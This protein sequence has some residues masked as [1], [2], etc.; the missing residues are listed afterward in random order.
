MANAAEGYSKTAGGP[1]SLR[2]TALALQAARGEKRALARVPPLELHPRLPPQQVRL[3][4]GEQLSIHCTARH[5]RRLRRGRRHSIMCSRGTWQLR[6]LLFSYCEYG[7]SSR[8]VRCVP[9]QT[10]ASVPPPVATAAPLR[11]RATHRA[12]SS[13]NFACAGNTWRSDWSPLRRQIRSSR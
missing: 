1:G 7:G 4:L 8:G 10:V 2:R 13:N 9:H 5:R 11:P 3:P 12:M 6:G